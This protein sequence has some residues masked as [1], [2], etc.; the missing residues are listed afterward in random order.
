MSRALHVVKR[1]CTEVFELACFISTVNA[2]SLWILICNMI[3]WR[4]AKVV[5]CFAADSQTGELRI[6]MSHSTEDSLSCCCWSKDG[7][8]FY[9]GGTKGQFYQC[10]S[11]KRVSTKS[12][13]WV[14]QNFLLTV[15]ELLSTNF[16][17][18]PK[19]SCICTQPPNQ[20]LNNQAEQCFRELKQ[21]V[22]CTEK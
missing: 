21:F 2:L 5:L 4:F 7:Q 6:K 13:F 10:V 8:K 17:R 12:S 1:K 3:A 20:H 9:A 18:F 22:V 14:C 11:C 16:T 15:L 19:I